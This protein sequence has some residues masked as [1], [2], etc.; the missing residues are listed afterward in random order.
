MPIAK[1]NE[2]ARAALVLFILSPV[3]SY[4]L[5]GRLPASNALSGSDLRETRKRICRNREG[6]L[7][8][9]RE[10]KPWAA[11]YHFLFPHRRI[12]STPHD[13]NPEFHLHSCKQVYFHPHGPVTHGL[14]PGCSHDRSRLDRPAGT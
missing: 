3:L 14:I 9:V 8:E 7:Q 10:T 12:F 5:V 2:T 4:S 6:A 13:W 11:V 1:A